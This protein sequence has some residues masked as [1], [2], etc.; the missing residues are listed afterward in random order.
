MFNII[1]IQ[2]MSF[3]KPLEASV[4]RKKGNYYIC[5]MAL[6]YNDVPISVEVKLHKYYVEAAGLKIG[7]RFLYS[8]R[9]LHSWKKV[10]K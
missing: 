10:K 6:N 4:N 5:W 7:D 1:K 8:S 3:F 2:V 9:G